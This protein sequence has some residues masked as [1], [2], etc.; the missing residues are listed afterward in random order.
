MRTCALL[1]A[2]PSSQ[3][4]NSSVNRILHIASCIHVDTHVNND[5]WMHPSA[6]ALMGRSPRNRFRE[7]TIRVIAVDWSGAKKGERKKIWLAEMVDGKPCRLEDGRTRGELVDHLIELANEDKELVVGLDFVFSLPTWFL[8]KLRVRSARGL[9][10]QVRE[11]GERWLDQCEPPFWGRKGKRRP[12]SQDGLRTTDRDVAQ[13]TGTLPKS[14]FQIG[15]AGAVGTGSL[16]GIPHLLR[17]AANN[18][19]IWPFDEPKLPLA[20]EIYPRLLTGAVVKA[21]PEERL[22][23]IDRCFPGLREDWRLKAG[24]SEDAFDAAVSALIM[25]RHRAAL[26]NL[27]RPDDPVLLREGAIWWPDESIGNGGPRP[28]PSVEDLMATVRSF[29]EA[30]DW[31]QFHTPKDLAIGL[32]TEASE[33]LEIFRF[34]SDEQSAAKLADPESRQAIENELAD[35]LFFLLRFSQRFDIDLSEALATKMALNAKRYP[36]EKSRG[37]NLKSTDL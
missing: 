33:L 31:D 3:P 25:D 17:L 19:S 24:D 12:S 30:R 20:I 13:R 34:L 11:H 27:G 10:K 1:S 16:R 29:C 4:W 8:E 35:V 37:K 2:N 18:F 21:R 36:V 7:A 26:S 28:R 23:H 22:A 9:R 6:S 32:A 5:L 14:V 15:G